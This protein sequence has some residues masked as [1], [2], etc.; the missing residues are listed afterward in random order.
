LKYPKNSSDAARRARPWSAN[1]RAITARP[2]EKIQPHRSDSWGAFHGGSSVESW[3]THVPSASLPSGAGQ[4]GAACRIV[5]GRSSVDLCRLSVAPHWFNSGAC[6]HRH[7]NR[8][9][10]TDFCSAGCRSA[11]PDPCGLVV[12]A[13]KACKTCSISGGS[14]MPRSPW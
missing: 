8:G 3:T 2:A 4:V 12:T 9:M 7:G 5:Y 14:Y 6:L 10:G 1:A 13:A 11:D